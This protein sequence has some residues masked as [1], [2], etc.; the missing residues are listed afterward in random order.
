MHF[1]KE[2]ILH[3]YKML[4]NRADSLSHSCQLVVIAYLNYVLDVRFNAI[5]LICKDV[6]NAMYFILSIYFI[7][8]FF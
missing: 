6:F 4:Y 7:L 2:K 8:F 1:H 5:F 3:T